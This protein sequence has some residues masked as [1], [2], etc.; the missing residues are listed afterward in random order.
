MTTDTS[1]KGLE[2]LICKTLT[3][4]PCDPPSSGT[5]AEPAEGYG[6]VG[7]S[8]GNPHDYD[9][10]YCV[11]LVQLVAFLGDTQPEA[12]DSLALSENNPTRQKF[13]AWLQG[14]ISKRGTIDVLRNGLKHLS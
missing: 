8:C 11:D 9:R 3:G 6:G 2:R 12:A 10:T 13:L 14:Q 5:V 7:W 1:E 4:H